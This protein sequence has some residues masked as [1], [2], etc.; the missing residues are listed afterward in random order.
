MMMKRHLHTLFLVVA[1]TFGL[2]SLAQTTITTI[3]PLTANNG[4]TAVTFEMTTTNAIF[5]TAISN[6]FNT[7]TIAAQVWYRVGGVLHSGATTPNVTTANGWVQ[8]G[9]VSVV[10]TSNTTPTAIPIVN[11]SIP[12]NPGTPVGFAVTG[13]TRYMTYVAANTTD[14]LGGGATVKT[15]PGFGFGGSFPNPTI[16]T[17]QF[18][19]S[20][21]FV[22]AGPCVNPPFVGPAISNKLITCSGE[23]FTLGLDSMTS[24]TG[25]LY[26]WQISSDNINWTNIVGATGP[27]EIV[28]QTTTNY[29]RCQVTCGVTVNSASVQV[30]TSAV[31]L[32][33]GTYTINGN[34]ATSGTNF[35]TFADFKQAIVCGGIAGPIVVNVIAKGSAY[36]EQI[37]FGAIGG[38]S[39]TNTIT[40]N[41]NNQT[42]SFGGGTAQYATLQFNGAQ[43]FKIKNLKIEGTGTT[44]CF[45]VQ[46]FGGARYIELDSCTVSINPAATSSSTAAFVASGS[47][48]S[49]TTAGLAARD[50]TIKNSIFE[51]GYYGF[52]LM[53][54]TA[55]PFASNNLIENNIIRDFYIYGLYSSNQDSTTYRRNDIN[56]AT[57]TGTIT[58]FY[59]LF[60][61]GNMTDVRVDGN[62]IHNSGDSNPASTGANYGLYCSATNA[63][64]ADPM[65][66]VNNAIY[67][68]NTAGLTNA[69]YVLS[70]NYLN[71]Y[72]NTVNVTNTYAT[73]ATGTQRAFHFGAT[74]GNFEIK[75]NIFQLSH[76]GSGAKHVIYL[77]SAVPTYSIDY[78]QY[79]LSA[80][81]GVNSFGYYATANVPTFAAW[82][83]VNSGAFDANGTNG[84]AVFSLTKYIPQSAVG[85]G[86]GTNLLSFVAT[87]LTGAARTTTPDRGAVEFTPM[88]CL[89]P[90]N[91]SATSGPSTI[92]LSWTNVSGAD[93]VKIEYGPTGFA[94]GTG[95]IAYGTTTAAITGLLSNT[96]YDF[97]LTSYCGGT[98][99][100]STGLFTFCTTCGPKATPFLEGFESTPVG[101]TT[102]MTLPSCWSL[103]EKGPGTAYGYATSTA[104]YVRTGSR[105]YYTYCAGGTVDT[106]MLISPEVIDMDSNYKQI[107]LW[108]KAISTSTTYS[109]KLIIG[110]VSSPS[111]PGSFD[112][113]DTLIIGTNTTYQYFKTFLTPTNGF[114]ST[115]K[116]IAIMNESTNSSISLV[117]I[118]DINVSNVPS[119][120][121]STGLAVSGITSS[122]ANISWTAGAGIKYQIEYGPQGFTQGTGPVIKGISG[123]SYTLTGLTAN[124][125]Y[126]VYMRDSCASAL[127]PWIGPI[128]FCT[129]CNSATMPYTQ[130]FTTWPPACFTLSG[131]TTWNWTHNTAGY[132]QALFW[133]NSTGVVTMKTQNVNVNVAAWVRFKWAHLYSASYPDDRL[134]LRAKAT[135]SAVWDTLIDLVGPTFTS[136][137]SSN[138]LPPTNA[139]NF[140]EEQLI[141]DPVKF[142]NKVVE[143]EFIGLTDFGPNVYID[144]FVVEAVPACLPPFGVNM[145]N[146]T[147]TSATANWSTIAGTCFKIEYGPFGFTQGTGQGTIINNATNPTTLTG[148]NPNTF[149]SVYI[150]DCCNPNVWTGPITFKTNCLS[151]LSGTYTVGGTPGPSN[152]ATLDSAFQALNGCGIT[153]PVTFNLQAGTFTIPATT[154]GTITGSSATNTVTFNG[155]NPTAST[156][157]FAAGN[158]IG[159]TFNAAQYI[160]FQNLTINA[161]AADRPIW[162]YNG[163]HHITFNNCDILGNTTSTSSLTTVI[164][165]TG[166]NASLS[167]VGDNA[168][169]ITVTNCKLA[170]GYYGFTVYGASTTDYVDNFVLTDNEFVDQYYYGVRLYYV[171][172]ITLERNSIKSFR[173]TASYGY[174][175]L[176]NSNVSIKQNDIFAST[177]G[178]YFSQLN[179]INATSSSEISNNFV[180]GGTYGTYFAT[181]SRL[182]VYHNSIRGNTSGFYGSAPGIDVDVRNN[183]FVGGTSY[184]YYSSLNPA[185]GY[186]LNYNLYH[187]TG[188]NLAYNAAAFTSLTAWQ[189][190]QPTHNANSIQG[191][192]G[193]LSTTD[194]HIIGNV[195]NNLG[196][197]GLS[198]V[199]FDNQSRPAS[200][201]TTVDIGA[202]EYTPVASD[203]SLVSGSLSKGQCLSTND[204]LQLVVKNI[205][206]TTLDMSLTNI[207]ANWS[208]TGPVNSTGTITVNSGTLAPN[209][210]T[211]LQTTSVNLSVPGVYTYNAYLLPS[212]FNLLA[213]NDTLA[214]GTFTVYPVWTVTPVSDTLYSPLDSADLEVASPFFGGSSFFIT[215]ICHFAGASTGLPVGG[216]PSWL[217][218]D[219]YIEI[220]GV[221]GSDLGGFTLEQWSTTAIMSTYTF[222]QGTVLS[223]NG[224]AILAVGQM[225]SSVPSP[226]NFY[227]HGVP[228]TPTPPT[229]SSG[230]SNGRILKN[231]SGIIVDAVGSAATYVFP[232]TTGVTTADWSTSAGIGSHT[233]TWGI[234]LQGPDL[235][236]SAGWIVSS[237]TNPQNP[238][239][240]NTGVTPPSPGSIAGFTWSL[241]GNVVDTV[242][243][244]TVGHA[245]SGVYNYIATFYHACD[246][247]ITIVPIYVIIPGQCP[248][249]TNLASTSSCTEVVLS[250]TSATGTI[251]SWVEYG[252][253]GYTYGSGTLIANAANPLTISGLA[254][255]TAYDFY[256]VD[257]C[258]AGVSAPKLISASTTTNLPTNASFTWVQGSTGLS[259]A[260]MSFDAS[261]TTN[262]LTYAWDFGDAS[263]SGSGVSPTHTYNANGTYI[264]TL[265]VTG[266]CNN[267]VFVDTVLIYGISVDES[268]LGKSLNIYPNPSN[269]AFRVE[270][271]ADGAEN[272]NVSVL[273]LLGQEVYASKLL[274]ESG[275]YQEEIDLSSQAAG[276]YILQISTDSQVVSKRITIR[277]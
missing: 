239:A 34:A 108:A 275:S 229:F 57:R 15:G 84:D 237:S 82:Q 21:T 210:T 120:I 165:V 166:T 246:T 140:I 225:G 5:V 148:L 62:K 60:L 224:T 136:P 131:T 43:Y 99:G 213:L 23:N 45:G 247:F 67:E 37:A 88:P 127:S 203:I 90:Y 10:V 199:D 86:N 58:T 146:I 153:A 65:Y 172:N 200:G 32:P 25:Q 41:G 207:V 137:G 18:L 156:I 70:G 2:S 40:I 33:A 6:T 97:Y 143:F 133:N 276:V 182:N 147:A 110:T 1:C 253:S 227:Y 274:G 130:P 179:A 171:N 71:F 175:G 11:M 243:A 76:V 68:M 215:E 266:P 121:P 231:S 236:G 205:I 169:Y 75:N 56:R 260:D 248:D 178:M 241:N 111:N 123:T 269:G 44:T 259:S 52:T 53:G 134:I 91:Y 69:I 190:A 242:P 124:T 158:L 155:I 184:A 271:T 189:T 20:V 145:T 150:A 63:T 174:Y 181:Y 222:P 240:I 106:F 249:P 223:P 257:S 233:S 30:T 163:T 263:P 66:L 12:V 230:G 198:V 78:N 113:L 14:F 27:Q 251:A 254:P 39:A 105:A 17:R 255:A 81:A 192:P 102:N 188:T 267:D 116:Y 26:Q 94:Q 256:I 48:T 8:A 206:G 109:N 159:L 204:T 139:A 29:Y 208:V 61:L 50:I 59:G 262:A 129:T 261:A 160:T 250:W 212:T 219:D 104:T 114:N 235:N 144:E 185:T 96:C 157:N 83:A 132:A 9:A 196:L 234:R 3:P 117:A 252:P 186:T 197:N 16:A 273:T 49:A 232:T 228:A 80:S 226:A 245:I 183:I 216:K 142:L 195:P 154:L 73:S 193:F 4:S 270:F 264:V 151:Q 265:S 85:D 112:P 201:S 170:G 128:N 135:T 19:G 180:G 47:L 64:L 244:I 79:Y 7:G 277:K 164:A 162:M 217:M 268:V 173:N 177:Y 126:S 98:I 87:D 95:L 211:V 125:C 272:V 238:N 35:N 72:H 93:S 31:A 42:L 167:A 55:A 141:L 187:A 107:E 161:P 36:N 46:L 101:S 74:T 103:F 92:T 28:S 122:S 77:T 22:P 176:Y 149:Y 115:H 51:G 220:T 202:D 24:G 214:T 38:A 218:A 209:A 119:C 152:F 89:Q 191:N 138:T 100:N 13:G 194:H 54:P 258:S 118:D 221:P 168:N